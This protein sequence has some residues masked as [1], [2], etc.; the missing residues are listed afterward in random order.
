MSFLSSFGLL[1]FLGLL[2][3][4]IAEWMKLPKLVGYLCTGFLLGESGFQILDETART[5]S[6]DLRKIALVM[7]L[8]RA[9]L[10]LS[11]DRL[12]KVGRPAIL[13]SFCPALLE[14]FSCIL[15]AP[16]FFGISYLEAGILG[17]ILAA[18]SPAVVVPRM[19]NFIEKGVGE[20]SQSPEI[21][22]AGASLDDVFVITLFTVLL[23]LAMGDG[24]SFSVLFSVPISLVSAVL[25]GVFFG[26]YLLQ[27][28]FLRKLSS[29]EWVVLLLGISLLLLELEEFLPFSAL[30][31]VLIMAMTLPKTEKTQQLS[32][33][34]SSLWVGAELLLFSLVGAE[35]ALVYLWDLGIF[36][37][38][39]LFTGLVLRSFGVFIA[40]IGTKLEKNYKIFV[41]ISYLP[42]A[43]VQAGIGGIPLA[44]G[45]ASGE[46]M[47]SLAVFSI[48][49]TAPLGAFFIDKFGENLLKDH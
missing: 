5:I 12:K 1:F 48:V 46:L 30:L 44:L 22:L 14:I 9:G 11:W 28:E 15:L 33:A 25:V 32:Q 31:S 4:K 34:F 19:T 23:S 47:L 39:L 35:V 6:P 16:L 26:K 18:V 20:K 49:A 21:V 42:K 10:S 24:F 41:A 3:G 7:I 43:T 8:L 45:L 37:V 13:L 36:A 2:L 29:S 17:T 27:Q 38:I 40:L